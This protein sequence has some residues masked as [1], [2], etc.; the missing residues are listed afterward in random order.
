MPGIPTFDEFVAQQQQQPQAEQAIPAFDAWQPSMIPPT[1]GIA[2]A[3]PAGNPLAAASNWMDEVMGD[4]R[5]GTT[6]TLPGRVLHALGAKGTDYGVSHQT[7]EFMASPLLGSLR[8]MKGL[9][10]IPQ[11]QVMQ[12]GKDLIG[13]AW[14]AAQIPMGLLGPERPIN[15]VDNA[16]PSAARAGE[17]FQAVMSKAENVTP[18]LSNARAVAGRIKELAA[19]GGRQPQVVRQFVS[20]VNAPEAAPMNYRELFDFA[21]NASRLSAEEGKRLTP[22]VKREVGQFSRALNEARAAAADQVGMRPVFDSAMNEYRNAARMKDAAQAI[23]KFGRR[24]LLG[25]TG[26]YGTYELGKNM[27]WIP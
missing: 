6:A 8:A 14:Q 13:G 12:G 5:N 9:L 1:A 21:S 4:V 3:K 7:G 20:R 23:K 19:R 10:E 27:G 18:D 2:A 15:A 24:G 11:G 26:A 22:V 17:K 25:A 16:I